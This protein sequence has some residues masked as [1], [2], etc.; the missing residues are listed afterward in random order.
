MRNV[1]QGNEYS[2]MIGLGALPT[3]Q[4]LNSMI[5]CGFTQVPVLEYVTWT[6]ELPVA[7]DALNSTFANT[8]DL[9]NN[10]NTVPGVTAVDS[11]FVFNGQLQVDM[12]VAGFG[13]H[14]FGEPQ[15]TS[16]I[17]NYINPKP[18]SGAVPVS[19]DAITQNDRINGALG[20]SIQAGTTTITEAICEWGGPVQNAM[21]HLVNGYQFLWKFQQRNLLVNELAADVAYFGSYAAAD[22]AGTSQEGVQ[23]FI[24]RINDRYGADPIGA[25]GAF[26]PI[27][28]QRVGSTGSPGDANFATYHPTRAYDLCDVTYGGLA[29]QEAVSN[30]PFRRLMKPVL[31]ERG[32]P[33]GMLLQTQD[34][35]HTKEFLRYM[36]NSDNQGGD[37]V[38]NI[39]FAAGSGGLTVAG[40]NIFNELTLDA[41][42]V[43]V[44]EQVQTDRIFGKGGS[45]QI[46]ILIKGFE[47]WGPWRQQLAQMPDMVSTT[48]SI[49]NANNQG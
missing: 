46:A 45:L 43:S 18:A 19:P 32:L 30:S 42:P 25:P 41:T 35:Y 16:F 22:A 44:G 7:D 15:Q 24:R 27:N 48:A 38:A 26:V 6:V 9:L 31:L 1:I 5:Q 36:S 40:T 11:S 29:V 33:I 12:L 34:P 28:A 4:G 14:V 20:P 13:V 39:Q 8:I 10:P 3:T 47:V 49:V 17:C 37:T 2:R 23:R 21:W